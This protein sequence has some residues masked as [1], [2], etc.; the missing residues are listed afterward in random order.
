M[1]AGI[2]VAAEHH[3]L[4][5]LDDTGA[6]IGKPFAI[7]EDRDGY[8]TLLKALGPPP[9]WSSW[10][11]PGT[12]GRT[13][14]SRSPLPGTMSSAQPAGRPALSGRGLERT[15]TD[16]IDAAGLA[17]FG[18][19]KRP[20]P[21]RLHD[22]AAEALRE[23]VRHRDR[24]R[25]DFDDRV[26][27]LHRLVDLCFPEFTRYVRSLDSMLA[28][29]LLAEFPTAQTFARA[30]PL[31]PRQAAL[32]WLPFGPRGTR[33]RSW[34]PPQNARLA[35]ITGRPMSSRPAISAR[36]STCGDAVGRN[37]TRH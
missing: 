1:I 28:T 32:R 9:L 33:R 30:N 13:C 11:R 15:K 36:I 25:R 24:L 8:D 31:Q 37:R 21:T 2:D 35:N 23:L 20:A 27:Q 26:R 14:L 7:A 34:L 3:I 17:R 4:A 6:P 22:E 10:R 29:C 18:F 19:E 12:T 5:R 16:T